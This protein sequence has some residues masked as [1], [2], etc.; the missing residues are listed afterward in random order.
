MESLDEGES[1]TYIACR[2]SSFYMQCR[3]LAF[4]D[5]QSESYVDLQLSS[6]KFVK[7]NSEEIGNR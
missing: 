4:P 1:L 5:F 7:L 3:R 2:R 6:R